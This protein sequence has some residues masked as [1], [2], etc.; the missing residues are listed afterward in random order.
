[1]ITLEQYFRGKPHPIAH[2]ANAN[3]LL[4]ALNLYL[5]E[6]VALGHYD[7]EIDPDT[8]SCISGAKGGS[9]DGGYRLPDSKT[10]A[11]SSSHREAKGTDVCD[12]LRK[13]AAY[14][15][16]DAGKAHMK[17]RGL[18]MED[19]RWTPVWCHFQLIA[20]RSGHR[21]Y[22]PAMTRALA[23]DLPGQSPLPLALQMEHA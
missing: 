18:Y 15:V 17:K 9:G 11:P 2:E 4:G 1:M 7:W 6:C 23:P 8:D 10:G 13:L 12:T 3:Y 21:I 16:T 20:P 5:H 22:I 19:P 14:C